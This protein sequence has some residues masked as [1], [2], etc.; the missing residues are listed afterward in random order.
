MKINR[1]RI[2]KRHIESE[3]EL[4]KLM[5]MIAR[6]LPN[7]FS[8]EEMCDY[9]I[10]LTYPED[11]NTIALI[12]ELKDSADIIIDGKWMRLRNGKEG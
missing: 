8:I 2:R 7:G 9:L 11:W 10:Q 1:L 12:E 3:D 4:L 5:V 6:E